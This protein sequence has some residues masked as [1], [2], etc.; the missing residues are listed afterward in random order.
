MDT[1]S[2]FMYVCCAGMK[3]EDTTSFSS[4]LSTSQEN[5]DITW[6]RRASRYLS[7][8]RW[9]YSPSPA[10]A[11]S[12]SSSSSSASLDE[13]WAHFEHVTLPRRYKNKVLRV[14]RGYGWEDSHLYPLGTPFEEML[15]HFGGVS[16]GMFLSTLFVLAGILGVGGLLNI[17]LMIYFWG[18]SGNKESVGY[19]GIPTMIRASALCDATKWVECENCA[20]HSDMPSYRFDYGLVKKNVCDFENFSMSGYASWAASVIMLI[21][22]VW[23]F[24]VQ[25]RRAEVVLDEQI[26]TASD[27][28]IKI[29]NPP[30]DAR[31]P[32]EW[33]SFFNQFIDTNESIHQQVEARHDGTVVVEDHHGGGVVLVTIAIDNANL[34][35]ALVKR[36]ETLKKISH[37][38]PKGTNLK[39]HAAVEELLADSIRKV[40]Y[41]QKVF[42]SICRMMGHERDASFLWSS[43]RSLEFEIRSIASQPFEAKAVFVTFDSERSQRNALH[44][45]STGK[46]NIWRN[47]LDIY[48][49]K[50]LHGGRL[51]IRESHRNASIWDLKEEPLQ[52][53][54]IQ[55]A[56][57]FG[58]TMSC[59]RVLLFRGERVLR[60]KEAVE[61]SDVRWVDLQSS[62]RQRFEL[63]IASALGM[64]IFIALSGFVIYRLAR[65]FPSQYAA[66][67]I[68]FTNSFVPVVCTFITDVESHPTE[69][70][71]QISLYIKMTLFRWY[72]SAVAL[73]VTSTFV[74]TISVDADFS[75]QSLIYQVYPV[76]LAELFCNPLLEVMD[77]TENF[78]KHI[79]APRGRDQEEMNSC[80]TGG[81]FWLAERY[82]VSQRMPVPYQF[83]LVSY[84]A[85]KEY[86]QSCIRSFVL[87]FHFT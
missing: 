78:R 48:R 64:L 23:V 76:I 87:Q 43:I 59:S 84:F 27:Y 26:Q 15:T 29:S 28:S 36:R 52:E 67:F 34:L 81:T 45:L 5:S 80:F 57:S 21:L 7:Q 14:P 20:D 50:L 75:R 25:Q 77:M 41:R 44:A 2:A 69:H 70:G 72:N 47:E 73:S 35:K 62:S 1:R 33:R 37:L 40:S 51:R 61:P 19:N 38:L 79:L 3:R 68:T 9:Y 71:K 56:T 83:N 60:V 17:P 74:E 54:T 13:A 24:Y 10:T 16:V 30:T 65:N 11:A 58:S 82:T 39:D 63:H 12:S 32:E 53:K 8:F 42:N 46:L 86:Q 4:G 49:L 55:L 31:D 6:S 66:M 22:T 18:Y 85:P